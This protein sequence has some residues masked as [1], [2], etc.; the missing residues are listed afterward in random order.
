MTVQPSPY[1]ILRAIQDQQAVQQA[2]FRAT[3]RL[4]AMLVGMLDGSAPDPILA[5]LVE[6]VRHVPSE[7]AT[8]PVEIEVAGFKVLTTERRA[9]AVRFVEGAELSLADLVLEGCAANT[10]AMSSQLHDI[11]QDFEKAGA[12]LRIDQ[13]APRNQ[14]QAARYTLRRLDQIAPP[15][16]QPSVQSGGEAGSSPGEGTPVCAA[17]DGERHDTAQGVQSVTSSGAGE[18]LAGSADPAPAADEPPRPPSIEK[19]AAVDGDRIYGP[20]GMVYVRD[21]AAR[22]LDVLKHGDLFGLDVVAKRAKCQSAEVVRQA[23][24][25][26]RVNLSSIGLDVW[27]DKVNVRLR[28]AS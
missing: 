1:D 18:G 3:D 20:G 8:P 7:R 10:K 21:S 5:S 4:V 15:G 25:I 17:G 13:A 22:A 23:L 24:N 2:S 14:V 27:M 26:E 11:N 19:L 16:F 6:P 12:P 9:K 28:A